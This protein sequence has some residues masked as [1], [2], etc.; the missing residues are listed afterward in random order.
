MPNYLDETVFEEHIAKY[1][2]ESELYNQRSPRDFDIEHLC[3]REMFE[4]FLRAQP[5]VWVSRVVY[6]MV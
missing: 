3:D 6:E 5:E 1:L 4:R 2:A